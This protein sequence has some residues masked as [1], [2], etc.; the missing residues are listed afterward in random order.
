MD[1]VITEPQILPDHRS[2][3]LRLTIRRIPVECV[4]AIAAL[5]EHFWLEPGA[6]EARILSTFSDGYARIRAVA[7]RKALDHL[8]ARV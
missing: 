6:G 4:I 3:A 8:E 1:T 2:I 7:E 5:A